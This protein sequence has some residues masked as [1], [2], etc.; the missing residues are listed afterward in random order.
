MPQ[1]IQKDIEDYIVSTKTC[2]GFANRKQA[3]GAEREN[4]NISF[5]NKFTS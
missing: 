5:H 3:E 4:I 1:V 2:C